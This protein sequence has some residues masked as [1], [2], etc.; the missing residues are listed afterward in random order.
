MKVL[1]N[2]KGLIVFYLCVSIF[3]MF[4]VSRVERDNDKMMFEKNTYILS[5]NI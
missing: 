5:D 1:K 3:A 4:W 2:N